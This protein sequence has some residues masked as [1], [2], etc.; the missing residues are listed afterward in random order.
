MMRMF[1]RAALGCACALSLAACATGYGPMGPLG[2][3]SES[4]LEPGVW[5][6]RGMSNGLSQPDAAG[7]M[8][9]YRAAELARAA[10]FSHFQVLETNLRWNRVLTPWGLEGGG[11]GERARMRIRGVDGAAVPPPCEA[12]KG[13]CPTFSVA[14]VMADLAPLLNIR[15]PRAQRTGQ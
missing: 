10:G 5:E 4:A 12:E 11:A 3:Y 6:V 15:Q 1:Q 2:G 9:L 8:A 14:E 13:E 7:N